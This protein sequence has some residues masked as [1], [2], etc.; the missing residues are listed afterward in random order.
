ML[1][2]ILSF[3]QTAGYPLLF[4]LIA[5]ESAGVPLPGETALLTAAS[6]AGQGKLSIALVIAIAATAAIIGDNIGYLVARK[7]GRRLLQRP[8]P[9]ARQRRRVLEVG[10]PFFERH[11]PKAVFFGRWILGLRT[12]ASWLAGASHMPWRTFALWNAVGGISWALTIGLVGYY[13]GPSTAGLFSLFGL[14]GLATVLIAAV[15]VALDHRRRRAKPRP[16][17]RAPA[18]AIGASPAALG[19]KVSPRRGHGR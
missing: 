7:G 4:A 19:P 15:G 3:T 14:I 5:A 17:R 10:E 11:G 9:F 12:W 1:A 18:A 6:L 8:G 16:A 13:V 2:S